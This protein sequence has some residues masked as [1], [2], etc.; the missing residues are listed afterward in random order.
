MNKF[1]LAAFAALFAVSGA[2]AAGFAL[3]AGSPALALKAAGN[4][5]APAAPPAPSKARTS[6]LVQVSGYVTLNGTAWLPQ[7]GGFTSVNLTGWATF[8]DA[9]GK[10]T[11]N[12]TYLSTS[13]S[14]WIYPN[15]HV[16]QTV[17]PNVYVQFYRNGK[18]VGSA[19]MTGGIS[20][21]GWP[22]G[23]TVMLSGSGYLNGS[24]YVEDEQ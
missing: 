18:P 19:N 8:R 3:N 1:L 5:P 12:N 4:A 16:F 9:A 15:Q 17:W 2:S 21:S 24:L 20:V 11:S 6:S 13:A 23:A 22:T 14:M 10:V 7:N